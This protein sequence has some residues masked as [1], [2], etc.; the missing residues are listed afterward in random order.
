MCWGLWGC[1]RAPGGHP[2]GRRAVG[3]GGA[4]GGAHPLTGRTTPHALPS[5]LDGWMDGRGRTRAVKTQPPGAALGT[6]FDPLKKGT[7]C[8]LFFSRGQAARP[9]ARPPG[10][11]A[12][13]RS[14]SCSGKGSG[15]G[16]A[17]SPPRDDDALM[18]STF[19]NCFCLIRCTT[20]ILSLYFLLYHHQMS[21]PTSMD[22]W[23]LFLHGTSPPCLPRPRAGAPPVAGTPH[24]AGWGPGRGGRTSWSA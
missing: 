6:F 9:Y 21:S 14:F 20:I 16:A 18:P 17:S 3:A 4:R 11:R 5:C 24:R 1:G 13:S 10:P 19:S 7:S 22:L 15:K 23:G 8:F 2:R 12:H